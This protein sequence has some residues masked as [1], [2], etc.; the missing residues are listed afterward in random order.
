MWFLTWFARRH[1]IFDMIRMTSHDFWHDSHD[2]TWFLRWFAWRHMIFD[3]ICMTS[4]DSWYDSHDVIWFLIWFAWRHKIFDMKRMTSH[5]SRGIF[6]SRSWMTVGC[7]RE[8]WDGLTRTSSSSLPAEWRNL[9][10]QLE[11][12][13]SRPCSSRTTSKGS[14]QCS[15]TPC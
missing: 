3:M 15:P 10:S 1:M 12:R 13:T 9:W 11:G 7:W 4:H 2:V 14:C 5:D 8:T 6:F